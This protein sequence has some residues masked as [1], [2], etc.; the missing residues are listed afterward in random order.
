[1]STFNYYLSIVMGLFMKEVELAAV[2]SGF[3]LKSILY[4][5]VYYYIKKKKKINVNSS[6]KT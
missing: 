1:M 4:L 3:I 2:N 6:D 5:F